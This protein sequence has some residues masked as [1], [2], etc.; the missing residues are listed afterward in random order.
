M[1]KWKRLLCSSLILIGI[2]NGTVLKVIAQ[3]ENAIGSY[4]LEEIVW[5]EMTQDS[6][7]ETD[8]SPSELT[9]QQISMLE[10]AVTQFEKIPEQAGIELRIDQVKITNKESIEETILSGE[11]MKVFI[12]VSVLHEIEQ[13]NYL[14]TRNIQIDKEDIVENQ[15]VFANLPLDQDYDIRT[16]L[17][18][19]IQAN[20][21]TAAKVLIRELGGI[22]HVQQIIHEMGFIQTQ[23]V[24]DNMAYSF[25]NIT[26]AIDVTNLLNSLYNNELLTDEMTQVALD[27]LS[28]HGPMM[29][30]Q[31]LESSIS[32]YGFTV[33][34]ELLGIAHDILLL[35]DSQYGTMIFVVLTQGNQ[36]EDSVNLSQIEFSDFSQFI[37]TTLSEVSE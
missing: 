7:N 4:I 27:I 24:D 1:K 33:Q 5:P 13:G 18:L 3:E 2:S 35:P 36:M 17:D 31:P 21:D 22:Q 16:L 9:S 29:L 25:S 12:L 6:Q 20:D 10:Y 19:M 28:Q 26:S 15:G 34:N 32:Y 23:L 8:E 11:L 37:L 30:A 14:L